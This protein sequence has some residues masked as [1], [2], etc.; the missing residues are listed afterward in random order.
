MLPIFLNKLS[1]AKVILLNDML[2]K[3]V[4]AVKVEKEDDGS[5]GLT[6]FLRR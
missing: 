4:V 6:T 2:N 5:G 3:V 1:R